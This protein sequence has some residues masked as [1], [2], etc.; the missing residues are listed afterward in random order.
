MGLSSVKLTGRH[1][2]A[3]RSL[4]LSGK[5]VSWP[6]LY[7]P[8]DSLCVYIVIVLRNDGYTKNGLY[9]GLQIPL[10]MWMMHPGS[11]RC[12]A[13][14]RQATAEDALCSRLACLDLRPYL[15]VL[16]QSRVEFGQEA[17]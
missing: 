13:T 7:L 11:A 10:C 6:A 16:K 17:R 12:T 15:S 4:A 2:E 1:A 3:C 8:D 5:R 14:C 9:W